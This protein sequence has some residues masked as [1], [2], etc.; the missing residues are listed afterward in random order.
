[1]TSSVTVEQVVGALA[2]N[3]WRA[4]VLPAARIDDLHREIESRRSGAGPAV[5]E[6]VDRNLRFETPA[7]FTA[8]SLVIVAVPHATARVTLTFGDES[9]VVPIPTTYCHHDAIHD[10]VV[11]AIDAALS[12]TGCDASAIDL[13]EKLLAVCAGLARYGRNNVA[14]VDGSGSYVELVAVASDAP[15][16]GDPWTGLRTLPRCE[17]CRACQRSCPSG[18]ID[19][20]RFLLHADRC[21]TLHNESER[22]FADWIDPSWH[23]CMVGCLR[24]QE[25]CPENLTARDEIG[26]EAAFDERE[27]R[28]LLTDASRA[29]LAGEPGLRAKLDQLGLLE[30]DDG[31]LGQVVPRNLRAVA[32]ARRSGAPRKGRW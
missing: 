28:Q 5:M 9:M 11:A 23:H 10:A 30:Y 16:A 21:L 19:G 20:D 22:P 8:R 2:A 25:A 15:P 17:G 29:A 3:G 18:A 6:V 26:E 1:M 32:A 4:A 7:G 14:Y 24:C 31:F 27:T 13:P 12:P